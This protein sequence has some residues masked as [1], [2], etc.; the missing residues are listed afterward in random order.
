MFKQAILRWSL[1]SGSRTRSKLATGSC[2]FRQE[3]RA[4]GRSD[5]ASHRQS[6]A[7]RLMTTRSNLVD[8]LR[9]IEAQLHSALDICDSYGI[10]GAAAPYID[11][12][13]HIVRHDLG[14][15]TQLL[16]HAAGSVPQDD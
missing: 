15:I 16:R 3:S 9:D 11:L 6:P 4:G 14:R 1:G 2:V 10:A 5:L 8:Q 7:E 13:M 12:A